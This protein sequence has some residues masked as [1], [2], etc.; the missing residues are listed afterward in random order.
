MRLLTNH[1][2]IVGWQ[3]RG[4]PHRLVMLLHRWSERGCPGGKACRDRHETD[5]L[6][7][8]TGIK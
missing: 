8:L 2:K 1:G 5:H 7:Y 6:R 3:R 4:R